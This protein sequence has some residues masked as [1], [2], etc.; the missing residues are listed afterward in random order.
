V[1]NLL[2]RLS[3]VVF[4]ILLSALIVEAILQVGALY[5][6]SQETESRS[7]VNKGALRVLSL[8]DSN[9]YGLHLDDR[10]TAYPMVLQSL[11]RK[12]FPNRPIEV[13]NAGV[14]GTNSSKLR[15]QLPSLLRT[16]QPDVVTVMVG[17]ND[18]W[19]EP[20]P[21]QPIQPIHSEKVEEPFSPWQYSRLYRLLYMLRRASQQPD[22]EV[23]FTD[24]EGY[25]KNRGTVRYG[26]ASFDLGWTR[27]AQGGV[28][29]WE[30]VHRD[31]CKAIAKLAR[32]AKVIPIFLTYAYPSRVYGA[33]SATVRKAA[34]D[35]NTP[36]IDVQPAFEK[37][38]PQGDC[39]D[40]YFPSQHPTVKGHWLIAEA[41]F[42][43]LAD[44]KGD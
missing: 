41:L 27:K 20:E 40:L 39:P 38:C 8:G 30:N 15:N 4:G 17:A 42:R 36:L 14:P 11:W 33:A 23:E 21:I 10:S 37:Q 3:L 19:T 1:R 12:R 29:N 32:E 24:P 16:F 22:V 13:I 35:T 44:I 9:T 5:I 2:V 31:N 6:R 26:E 7:W 43:K 28:T 18:F 34:V 25:R